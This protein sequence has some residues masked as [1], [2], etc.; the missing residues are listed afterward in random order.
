[1]FGFLLRLAQTDDSA[2]LEQAL[3][4][5]YGF[6]RPHRL[7]IAA[8][9][10]LSM[11]ATL[12]VLAQPML[13]KL[14]IDKGLLAGNYPV[15]VAT[16]ATMVCAGMVGNVLGGANRYLHTRLSGRI[17]FSL[18]SALYAHLQK[19]S[20]AFYGRRRIGDLLSRLD[21][22]VAEIQRFALDSLFSAVSSLIGLAG[23]V[24]LL[25]S[26]SWKLSLL[27]VVLIPFEFFW[28][29][30][31]RQKVERDARSLRQSSADLSCFL[32]ETL[33]AMKFIQSAGQQGA[34][35]RRLD[36]L[37]DG[38]MQRLLKL[39][40]TEFF[41]QSV[42]GT[43]TSVSRAGAFLVGG[44][45]VIHG[46]WQLGSLIAFST[47]MGMAVGPVKSLLGL[48]VAIQR[49][50]VS[51][52]RVIELQ[53]EPLTVRQP[54]H[55]VQ[56]PL[57]GCDL[58]LEDVWFA[59]AERND[60]VLRGI[61]ATIPAGA[62]VAISG[63]SGTGKSTLVDLLLRFYDPPQ[64]RVL[65][66]GTDLRDL[67]LYA[68]RRRIAV[69]SQEIILFRGSLAAN[70]AYGAPQSSRETI[71]RIASMAGLDGLIE[72]MPDG[73]DSEVGERG[74]QL[75]G[76]QKQRVAIARALLQDASILVLDESTS[77]L[78]EATERKLI[79]EVDRLFA[80]RTRI[81]I[82][83]RASTL[84]R[85]DLHLT[86]ADGMLRPHRQEHAQNA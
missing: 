26:L 1:M 73:L 76:G 52:G 29:R 50:T 79:A 56:P 38:Y 8:L 64:G 77:A 7:G 13:T 63:A 78:D 34:E 67:D 45:W 55:P 69:V 57:A 14:L 25:L 75:S 28:L 71:A 24:V 85:A 5:L 61:T 66:G 17:L 43:L 37:G 70:I 41:T 81:L 44:Y 16:A 19:L 30:W 59:H 20:P 46:E 3:A 15:L 49:V 23:A 31:M 11:C 58:R 65:F 21:G 74:Q 18:R 35:Q 80:S 42:P 48:Y 10:G 2:R 60:W 47:Y 33:P 40:L 12:L 9:L 36:Q 84:A 6:I 83:H 86:L 53:R 72:S 39:Q 22:D 51:L 27:I 32:V 68:L 54:R 62:K 4:W 82:S